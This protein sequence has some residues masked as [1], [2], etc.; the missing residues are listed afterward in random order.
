MKY[1]ILII[2][3]VV[4]VSGCKNEEKNNTKIETEHNHTQS[5]PKSEN[6]KNPKSTH[7]GN[8]YDR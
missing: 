4:A 8:G 5:E 6:K 3:L 2:L 1:K 7:I